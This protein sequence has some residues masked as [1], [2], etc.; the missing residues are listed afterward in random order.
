MFALSRQKVLPCDC[1]EG[2][3]TICKNPAAYNQPEWVAWAVGRFQ[4]SVFS[5]LLV[6]IDVMCGVSRT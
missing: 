4:R 5:G 1:H 3:V 2:H 6:E